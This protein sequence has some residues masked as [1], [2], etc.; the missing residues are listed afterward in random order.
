MKIQ[1]SYL[2]GYSFLLFILG[3]N[4]D[5]NN[6]VEFDI[7]ISNALIYDGTGGQPYKGDV[8]IKDDRIQGIGDLKTS[9]SDTVI[10]AKGL[11]LSPGFIDNHSHHDGGIGIYQD[12]IACVS[13][14]LTTVVV[15]QDGGSNYPLADFFASLEKTPPAINFASY[16][17]FGT[18]RSEVMKKD[19][20]RF[21]TQEEI[22]QMKTLAKQE[23]ASGALGL[24][25]GLEYDPGIYSDPS[26]IIQVAQTISNLDG[27][28]ISHMR[29][30]DQYIWEAI[31]ELL[32][33]GD[34]TKIPVQIS[35]IKLAWQD[36]FGLADS[37]LSILDDA[38]KRGINV[39]ADIY[40]YTY[41][42]SDLTVL[43]ASRDY[44]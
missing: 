15:G 16:I 44:S 3:C 10:D 9:T 35:H 38:R 34:K 30:E 18:I 43:M 29:N 22:E 4:A 41:W 17:G 32:N 39:T 2:I 42:N 6:E 40:P 21:A 13:Q 33:I 11:A 27:R 12:A 5:K 19:Y 37:L 31:D 1:V 7:I 24:S 25:T 14:G 23:M 8:G 26:E 28:Y 36:Y 20:K